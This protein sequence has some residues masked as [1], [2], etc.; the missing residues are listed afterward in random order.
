MRVLLFLEIT[1]FWVML[2][3][4]L[5]LYNCLQVLR[6]WINQMNISFLILHRTAM[7]EDSR[8]KISFLF[9]IILIMWKFRLTIHKGFKWHITAHPLEMNFLNL[10]VMSSAFVP[11]IIQNVVANERYKFDCVLIFANILNAFFLYFYIY[12][13]PNLFMAETS[14]FKGI[15]LLITLSA[16][17]F[18]L[19]R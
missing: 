17:V 8:W 4:A 19:Y 3:G 18:I 7:I 13:S 16:Q 6:W 12:F 2:L 1:R 11:Q 9:F 15:Y 10:M 5:W 14:P